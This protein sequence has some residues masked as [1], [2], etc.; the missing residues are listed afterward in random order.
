MTA[1][2]NTLVVHVVSARG[3]YVKGGKAVDVYCSLSTMGKGAWKS[4]VSTN[5]LRL[6]PSIPEAE[7]KWD[8]H[9]EFQL[10]E[11]DTKLVIHINHKTSFGTTETLGEYIFQLERMPRVQPLAW[12]KLSKAGSALNPHTSTSNKNRGQIQLGFQFSNSLGNRG[13]TSVSNMSLNKI[14]KEGKLYRLRRKMQQIGR[15]ATGMDDTISNQGDDSQSFASVSINN[16]LGNHHYGADD[17]RRSSLLSTNSAAHLALSS[18]SP[19]PSTQFLP[20]DLTSGIGRQL[21]DDAIS[22]QSTTFGAGVTPHHPFTN[23]NANSLSVQN[24]QINGSNR[25]IGAKDQ[26]NAY[27]NTS[28]ELTSFEKQHLHPN[29]SSQSFDFEQ[30][31]IDGNRSSISG[32]SA[33]GGIIVTPTLIREETLLNDEQPQVSSNKLRVK[34]RQKA[35][36]LLQLRGLT[37]GNSSSKK[38]NLTRQELSEFPDFADKLNRRDSLGSSSGFVSL[39]SGQLGALNEH[40]SPDYLLNVIKHLRNE[41]MK[42]EERIRSLEEYTDKLVAKVM[43]TNPE[44]L[45]APINTSTTKIISKK[46]RL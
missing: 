35:E 37:G 4:K 33:F 5:Q 9:C 14:D 45:A 29:A 41:L 27:V 17:H 20:D 40:T 36:Q 43:V 11:M 24:I 12:F 31:S 46:K 23:Q 7:I 13:A 39:G 44:L 21:A 30:S 2:G 15:K 22:T 42:K 1:P 28:S 19:N 3:L 18:P 32:G 10:N 34:M 6:D 38:Q 8:E 26:R 25:N 16:H